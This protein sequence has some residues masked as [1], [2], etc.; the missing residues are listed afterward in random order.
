MLVPGGRA[1]IYTTAPELRG[2]PA[3]REPVASCCFFYDDVAF[4][5]LVGAAGF[6]DVAVHS[7]QGGQ[8]LAARRSEA[9]RDVAA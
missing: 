3:V 2:K 8:L 7:Q 4:A 5:A 6:E 9:A 1:A